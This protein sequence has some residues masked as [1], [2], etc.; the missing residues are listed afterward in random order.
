MLGHESKLFIISLLLGVEFVIAYAI[1]Q[2]IAY[3]FRKK[4]YRLTP[5]LIINVTLIIIIAVFL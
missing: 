2:N 1:T 5:L 3:R 4:N